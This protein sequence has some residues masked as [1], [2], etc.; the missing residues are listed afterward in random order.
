MLTWLFFSWIRD[1]R[2]SMTEAMT[3]AVAGLVVITPGA[4]YVRPW[5]AAL[6]GLVGGI[7]CYG[8]VR[9]RI[10]MGWDDALDVWAVMA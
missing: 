5:A 4:G 7:A 9:F 3:G 2:P 8:A 10:K 1:S 6:I